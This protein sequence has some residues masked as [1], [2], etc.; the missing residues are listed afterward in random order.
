[1]FP[2]LISLLALIG[3]LLLPT[4]AAQI[5]AIPHIPGPLE[6]LNPGGRFDTSKDGSKPTPKFPAYT[7]PDLLRSFP[8]LKGMP[9]PRVPRVVPTGPGPVDNAQR[10]LGGEDQVVV[11]MPVPTTLYTVVKRGEA[12]AP[13]T[14]E[15]AALA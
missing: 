5:P 7:P 8:T 6:F 12:H 13:H 15:P 2:N 10:R 9:G 1:M 14:T 4:V 11:R 3:A